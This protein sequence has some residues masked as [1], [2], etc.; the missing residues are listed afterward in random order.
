MKIKDSKNP[1][2]KWW[3]KII[4]LSTVLFAI[5]SPNAYADAPTSGNKAYEKGDVSKAVEK[6]RK[7]P[8]PEAAYRI[9]TLAGDGKI[10]GCDVI[11]C[12]ASWYFKA[13][14][15]GHIPSITHLAIL[16]FNN[17]YKEVGVSQLQLAARWNDSLARDLLGQMDKAVP[18]PDLY[19]QALQQERARQLA[20]EIARQQQQAQVAQMLGYFI[21]CGLGG[22][23]ALPSGNMVATQP[24]PPA[25]PLVSP[26]SGTRFSSPNVIHVPP[27]PQMC[28]DG[29]YVIGTCRMAPNGRFVGGQPQM[30]PDGSYVGGTPRMTPNGRFVG[31]NGPT[32]M[33][34]DGSFVAG[35]C[36]LAP[37][38][39]Y[40]GQ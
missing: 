8:K 32:T 29:T 30:A 31:G 3:S 7:S 2:L 35:S 38:G 33:C 11:Y 15:G 24:A 25:A 19:N 28:P 14:T 22:G 36:R 17:G 6:W 5:L 12:T 40:V 34:P 4:V 16:N 39:E 20:A 1:Q 23:C 10:Q 27:P 18:E 13:A 9:A 37:N 21:G 26:M